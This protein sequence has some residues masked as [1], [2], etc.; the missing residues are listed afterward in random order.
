MLK[1]SPHHPRHFR[2]EPAHPVAA[3]DKVGGAENVLPDK[4]QHH[5]IDLGPLRLHQ[6]ENEGRRIVALVGQNTGHRLVVIVRLGS[7][8]S[9]SGRLPNQMP[10]GSR[11]NPL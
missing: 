3:N 1:V 6:V 10:A 8:N 5:A 4:I 9:H 7:A 11:W 2:I